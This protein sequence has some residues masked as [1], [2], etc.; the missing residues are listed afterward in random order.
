[1]ADVDF[2]KV[3]IRHGTGSKANQVEQ[4]DIA[5]RE[6][7]SLGRD[8]SNDVV[9]HQT[10]DD[11]VS[12]NHCAIAITNRNPLE[13]K[14]EDFG[15]S[16]GT[17]LNKR[18]L[19]T[20]SELLPDDI[21]SLGQNG[22]SF[23]FDLQPRPAHLI[24]RTRVMDAAAV[25]ATRVVAPAELANTISAAADSAVKS[26]GLIGGV[27]RDN[28]FNQEGKKRAIGHDT[29]LHAIETER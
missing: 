19:E 27:S 20:S 28:T 4:I 2:I 5:S 9:Y 3:I 10:I 23:T 15:S 24:A 7:I 14:I 29:M 18:R 16:N 22:P 17:Y 25:G 21:V 6:R 26:T 13:F 12:R 11:T 1:M 8:I